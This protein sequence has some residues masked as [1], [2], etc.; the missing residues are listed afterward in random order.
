[1]RDRIW[2]RLE[3]EG[4]ARFPWPVRGRIPNFEGANEAAN[5]LADLD[6]WRDARAIKTNPDSPQRWARRD[7]LRAGK[8]LYMAVPRLAQLEAF[9]ELNPRRLVTPEKAATIKGAFAL[10]KPVHPEQIPSLDLIL[11]GSVAVN[12][13]GGRLGKGGGYSDLEYAFGRTFGFIQESTPIVTTVHPLQLVAE[14]I[15]TLEHDIPVD[16]VALPDQVHSTNCTHR[17][18]KGVDWDILPEEKIRTIPVLQALRRQGLAGE[19][20]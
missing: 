8:V 6:V 17:R 18:P 12:K 4:V 15:P 13:S 10:G 5:R 11:T 9:L 1:M 20:T 19:E 7:A 14:A 2:D 16:F 3:T